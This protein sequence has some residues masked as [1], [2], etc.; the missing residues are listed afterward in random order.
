MTKLTKKAVQKAAAKIK[1][2]NLNFKRLSPGGKRRAI[3]TNIIATLTKPSKERYKVKK[4]VYF[5][6]RRAAGISTGASLQDLLPT[7]ERNCTV[8]GIGA[9]FV[10]HVRL[11]NKFK[12]SGMNP[13]QFNG[14]VIGSTA[15]ADDV[16][17]M[18]SMEGYFSMKDLRRIEAAFEG[19][20]QSYYYTA[21]Y[22]EIDAARSWLKIIPNTTA[23]LRA[24]AENGL[25]NKG[26]FNI[27]ELPTKPV[28]VRKAIKK[29][30]SRANGR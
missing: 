18:P 22:G 2:A 24:I 25:R 4:L 10:S 28:R 5:K 13:H 7:V 26:D 20:F 12:I 27:L 23:R 9:C 21:S 14:K 1:R 8:C 6:M 16:E 11:A 29:K 17:M 3:F 30:A 15:S 19:K